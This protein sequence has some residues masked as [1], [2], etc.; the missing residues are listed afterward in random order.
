MNPGS[1]FELRCAIEFQVGLPRSP[2]IANHFPTIAGEIGAVNDQRGDRTAASGFFKLVGPAAVIGEGFAFEEFG[3]VG[4]GFGDKEK[5]DFAFEVVAF[6]V[7]PLIF[8]SGDA[9]TDEDDG[10]VD[11]GGFGLALVVGDV[12]VVGL[13]RYGPADCGNQRESGVGESFDA[14]HRNGLEVRAIFAGGLESVA[15]EL[16]GDVV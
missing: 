13:E 10:S 11:V 2:R 14:D 8:G 7:V 4:G 6:V 1:G 9:K 15:L 16:I 3:I 12:V 5:S